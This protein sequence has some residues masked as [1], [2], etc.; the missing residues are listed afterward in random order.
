MKTAEKKTANRMTVNPT[1]T[2][3]S[4]PL[5]ACLA[6]A[7]A[8]LLTAGCNPKAPT[9]TTETPAATTSQSATPG[10]SPVSIHPN[11]NQA[12]EPHPWTD[13][14]ILTCTVSQCWHLANRSE[15]SFFDIVQQ[16]AAISATN[17][18]L[19]LPESEAAGQQVGQEIKSR[20]KVDHDQLLY[21]IVDDAVRKVGQPAAAK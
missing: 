19:T 14:Q 10:Q 6:L 3:I 4:K 8:L 9:P 21:A 18:D 20:T 16:L 12:S 5:P 13:Q 2:M 17:R 11:A 15:D 1:K 7:A